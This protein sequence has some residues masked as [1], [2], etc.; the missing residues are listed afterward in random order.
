M[1]SL[2]IIFLVPSGKTNRHKTK[3]E[4]EVVEGE[5]EV[6]SGASHTAGA[7]VSSKKLD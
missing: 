6:G 2:L 5:G 3:E 1:V 7:T 4:E